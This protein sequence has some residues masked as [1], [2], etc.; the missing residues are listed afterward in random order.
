VGER[1]RELRLAH[2]LTQ[3]T[4]AE[5]SGLSYKFI[6]EIERGKGNP[7]LETLHRLSVAL[8]VD[9]PQFFLSSVRTSG[10]DVLYQ[11]RT[12]DVQLLREKLESAEALLNRLGP[13]RPLRKK[14]L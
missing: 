2:R 3:E 1:V 5:R 13:A 8:G 14:A 7:T 6:G 11:I 9:I 4:L 12:R 10:P